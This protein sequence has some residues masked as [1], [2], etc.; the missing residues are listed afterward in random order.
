MGLLPRNNKNTGKGVPGVSTQLS[1]LS[2]R[3]SVMMRGAH[4]KHSEKGNVWADIIGYRLLGLIFFEV[5]VTWAQYLESL[6]KES[7]KY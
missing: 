3:E 4:T 6:Q 2:R 5:K 7:S 1:L